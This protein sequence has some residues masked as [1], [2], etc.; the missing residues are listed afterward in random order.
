MKR[1]KV[2]VGKWLPLTQILP[3]WAPPL[4]WPPSLLCPPF[5]KYLIPQKTCCFISDTV[6]T[7]GT[8]DKNTTE[9]QKKMPVTKET[10]VG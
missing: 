5:L 1:H 6:E 9:K 4:L 2:G 10:R 3:L 7:K 8:G